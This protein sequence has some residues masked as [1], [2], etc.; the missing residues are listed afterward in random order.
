MSDNKSSAEASVIMDPA[1][2]TQT[3]NYFTAH[4]QGELHVI[5]SILPAIILSNIIP[6]SSILA[7]TLVYV[8]Q[9]NYPLLLSMT[10]L[11]LYPLANTWAILGAWR[12]TSRRIN[13][14]K[15]NVLAWL[16]RAILMFLISKIMLSLI[17]Y[18]SKWLS[19]LSKSV[20]PA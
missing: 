5:L 8:T 18:L 2:K 3:G 16:V 6:A 13:Q 1:K 4:F 15:H 19:F 12:S 7:I 14:E 17:E 10:L 20:G 11:A 9:S